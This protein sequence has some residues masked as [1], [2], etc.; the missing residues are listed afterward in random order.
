MLLLVQDINFKGFNYILLTSF[1]RVETYHLFEFCF[2]SIILYIFL[3]TFIQY[4]QNKDGQYLFYSLYLFATF[5]YFVRRFPSF[6]DI[7]VDSE[8]IG[9]IR[10][11]FY[12]HDYSTVSAFS[13]TEL[14][15]SMLLITS[16][17]IFF[18]HFFNL[19]ANFP[20]LNRILNF[21]YILYVIFIII[22]WILLLTYGK[23]REFELFCKFGLTVPGAY[24]L[25]HIYKK[26]IRLYNYIITGSLALMA[27]AA[28][29]GFLFI[30]QMMSFSEAMSTFFTSLVPFKF[31]PFQIGALIEILFF[32]AALGFK[33]K[34]VEKEKTYVQKKNYELQLQQMES[35]M[36]IL[37]SQI[38]SHFTFRSL[39]T[40]RLLIQSNKLEEAGEYLEKF[41]FLL[42]AVMKNMMKS[43][44][45]L[46]KELDICEAY[47]KLE[48]SQFDHDFYFEIARDSTID[49]SFIEIPSFTLQPFVEN[50]IQHGLR[51]KNGEKNLW[52][53]IESY[54]DLVKCI[55]KDNGIGRKN[56]KKLKN[57]TTLDSHQGLGISNTE[58]RLE[59]YNRASGN[60]IKYR[61]NDL[62]NNDKIPAG[63][64]VEIDI[65]T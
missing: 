55:I 47:I 32:T 13:K 61:I 4:I 27:G 49:S 59:L 54:P 6:M 28:F 24:I 26:K 11:Y 1:N 52:I 40:V 23:S 63:T 41:S 65:Y 9:A 60:R 57:K 46:E 56:A 18:Q 34:L 22:D 14:T 8:G 17:S 50:A 10:D 48:A 33:S 45:S 2:L 21:G 31:L 36:K 44:I 12:F 25:Y 5:L 43:R 37:R 16:Y 29:T 58:N 53:R 39:S 64:Q 19:K 7:I 20:K 51:P 42:D 15:V 30:V 38:G 35:D 62:Y 3:F